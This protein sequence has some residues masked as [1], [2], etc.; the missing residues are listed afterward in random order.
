MAALGAPVSAYSRGKRE[1]RTAHRQDAAGQDAAG[2]DPAG[3]GGEGG[4]GRGCARPPGRGVAAFH[5]SRAGEHRPRA[6]FSPPLTRPAFPPL[7]R[8]SLQSF[9]WQI[10]P[11]GS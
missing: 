11:V 1:E 7:C 4:V 9:T 8:A 6:R 5:A 2:P 3:H 10:Q